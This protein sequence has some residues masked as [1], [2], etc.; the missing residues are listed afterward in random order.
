MKISQ[1]SPQDK[2][3]LAAELDGFEKRTTAIWVSKDE[4]KKFWYFWNRHG[5]ETLSN[6]A[7]KYATSYDAI[8][9]LIQ[10]QIRDNEYLATAFVKQL[11]DQFGRWTMSA[12]P[13]QLLDALLV[14]TGKAEV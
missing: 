10:K 3:K 11:G 8:I 1:L 13:S 5:V 6:D 14:A 2:I 7:P 9:P 4:T 12:T